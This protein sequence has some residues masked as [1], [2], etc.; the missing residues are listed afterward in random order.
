[1]RHDTICP[2]RPRRPWSRL[3]VSGKRSPL[4]RWH[5]NVFRGGM[6]NSR[7]DLFLS[8]VPLTDGMEFRALVAESEENTRAIAAL[9]TA[10]VDLP[11]SSPISTTGGTSRLQSGSSAISC[12]RFP[13]SLRRPT[14]GARRRPM[15]RRDHSCTCIGSG[16]SSLVCAGAIL[17]SL[18]RART[19]SWPEPG[20]KPRGRNPSRD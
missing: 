14:F 12:L 2:S 6:S 1:M 20:R 15:K 8:R 17:S 5:P 19:E 9:R 16:L 4:M 7:L 3:R 11:P 10:A 18:L 13:G